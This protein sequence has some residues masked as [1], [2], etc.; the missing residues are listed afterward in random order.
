MGQ[1]DRGQSHPIQAPGHMGLADGRQYHPIQAPGLAH[2]QA[3]S[4]GRQIHRIRRK[5]HLLTVP[6]GHTYAGE[7]AFAVVEL[8]HYT[9]RPKSAPA[10]GSGGG[11]A[12]QPVPVA[13]KKLK[14]EIVSQPED[15]KSFLAEVWGWRRCG[16]R[17][18][19]RGGAGGEGGVTRNLW[20]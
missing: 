6:F 17:G 18:R 15:L 8:C 19:G 10:G 2:Y 9:P 14:P 4:V 20:D 7:G 12:P 5:V 16:W 1:A 3:G 11:P 13:V